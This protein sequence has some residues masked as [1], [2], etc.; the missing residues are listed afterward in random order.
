MLRHG[1]DQWK[2]GDKDAGHFRHRI[3]EGEVWLLEAGGRTAGPPEPTCCGG[4]T[5]RPEESGRP[6]PGTCTA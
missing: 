6:S 5:C 2:P 1:I 4:T 3:A